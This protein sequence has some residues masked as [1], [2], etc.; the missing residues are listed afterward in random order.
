MNARRA[1]LVTGA[2]GHVGSEV[3]VRLVERG[4]PVVAMVH[5]KFDIVGN[6]GRPVRPAQVLRGDVRRADFGLD[7]TTLRELAAQVSTI[8]HCA[9]VTDFG[10]PEQ[11]YTDLNVAGTANALALAR[12]WDT[13]FLY[14]GTTYV[15]GEFNGTFGED[16]LDVGQRF[17]NDYERSKHRA[18]QLVRASGTPWA[19]VRPGI[20]SGD[21]RTG[22]SRE[23]KHIYQVLK[24]IVEGKLRTL[25]GNYAATLALSPVGHVANTIASAA[26]RLSDNA[27]RTFHAVGAKCVSLST[28][29][30]VLAEYPSF[31]IADFVPPSTFSV[32][33]LDEIE[34]GYFEKIGSLYASYLV[35]RLQF[36]SSNTRDRLGIIPP[37]TGAGYVRRIL[38]SCLRT[39]YLGRPGP[40]VA[41]VL[42]ELRRERSH[43]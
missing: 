1:F 40:S 22:H 35:R 5:N 42:A 19:V 36:D 25:P 26:E 4:H 37:P 20:V 21:H 13:E 33:Q 31:Q 29:S 30:D 41:D 2:A 28:L 3:V 14:V 24:L 32:E 43:A 23:H 16:Q 11:R 7:E 18:E 9:A 6:N 15:C 8:V 34:R 12:R 17:G 39:G 38:D 10:L 27:G